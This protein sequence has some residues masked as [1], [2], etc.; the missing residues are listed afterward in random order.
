MKMN[1]IFDTAKFNNNQ[2]DFFVERLELEASFYDYDGDRRLAMAYY[3]AMHLVENKL[4]IDY[5]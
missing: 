4:T 1:A 3:E 5:I 2:R